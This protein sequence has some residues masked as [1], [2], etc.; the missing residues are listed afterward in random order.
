MK[1]NCMKRHTPIKNFYDKE[2]R[3]LFLGNG[4]NLIG[5]SPGWGDL[6]KNLDDKFN[7]GINLKDKTYPLI[8]EEL[9]FKI[10]KYSFVEHNI[11]LLKSEI[12]AICRKIKP[13]DFHQD[14]VSKCGYNQFITTNYDYCIENT[15]SKYFDSSKG[16]N[17]KNRK[18]STRRFNIVNEKKIWHIHG[19][20]DN[21]L[22][23]KIFRREE[24][25]LIG[26]EHYN[27]YLS[28]IHKLCKG[29][30]GEG[31]AKMIQ[32]SKEN[33]VHLFFTRDIDIVGFGMNYSEAHLWFI[34]NF[35][36]RLKRKGA[37]IS[38]KIKFIE[39]KFNM[40]KKNS[41]Y[42]LL[43]TLDVQIELIDC[44]KNHEDFYKNYIKSYK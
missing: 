19:E 16:K 12:G 6:L 11:E 36:A 21:G 15:L 44:D 26:N 5:K 23:G 35:R 17:L 2:D 13:N 1:F 37:S 18:Y 7:V 4:I 42:S 27:D 9:A 33:W 10:R 3:V 32:N 40:T 22:R 38:N 20:I 41:L 14:L 28:K 30:N 8:F 39:P 25:I 31:L 24:S 29:D 43:K 34:L